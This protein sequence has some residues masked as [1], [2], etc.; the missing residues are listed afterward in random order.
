MMAED[1]TRPYRAARTAAAWFDRSA[2]GRIEV[3]GADRISWLQGLL[4]NDVA[5]LRPG[6]GCYAAYLTPQ[7][8]MISDLRVLAREDSC[9]LDVPSAASGRV[10]ERLETFII[11]EDVELRNLTAGSARLGVYGPGAAAALA[12]IASPGASGIEEALSSL[13]EHAHVTLV[14]PTGEMLVAAN[15][16]LGTSGFDLYV[17]SGARDAL[18]SAIEGHG[19]TALDVDTWDTCRIEAG[20]PLYGVDMDQETIPLEAGIEDRAISFTKGCYVGQ[21]VIV[22]VRDRGQGRVARRLMRLVADPAPDGTSPVLSA[23]DSVHA[24]REVGRVTSTAFSPAAGRRIA[25]AFVHRD[26]AVEGARLSVRHGEADVPV[27]VAKA[28]FVA[29]GADA[30]PVLSS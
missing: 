25:L 13:P 4:T 23:G 15:R 28:A 9:W 29:P 7:G 8:R 11:S 6:Q 12:A 22:R 18:V 3:R 27:T 2:E 24:D 19:V 14:G 20:R 26:H 21:E 5:A 16:D 30:L 1:I 17:T 10:L